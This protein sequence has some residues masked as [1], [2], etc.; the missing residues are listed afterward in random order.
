[1]PAITV[2]ASNKGPFMDKT[3]TENPSDMKRR[4]FL[5]RAGLVGAAALAATGAARSTRADDHHQHDEATGPL[6]NATVSF[7]SWQTTPPFDRHPNVNN[8]T[9]NQHQLSPHEVTIR[10]GGSVNFIIAGFHQ[11]LVYGNGVQL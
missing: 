1:M 6:A 4:S 11:I 2:G 10:A 8:R 7:G 3:P 9:R 5:S